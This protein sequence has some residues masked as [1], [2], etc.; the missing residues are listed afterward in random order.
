MADPPM[1]NGPRRLDLSEKY[2]TVSDYHENDLQYDMVD[3]P[4]I[5]DAH[6]IT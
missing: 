6:A 3:L 2:A 4:R 1:T 5:A